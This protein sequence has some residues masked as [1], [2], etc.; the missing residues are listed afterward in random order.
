VAYITNSWSRVLEKL[1]VGHLVQEIPDLLWN[2]EVHY[3]GHRCP[4][5]DS[6]QSQI[7]PVYTLVHYFRSISILSS[8]LCLVLPNGPFLSGF[9]TKLWDKT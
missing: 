1:I 2:L 3:W 4:T 5:P 7:N 9:P 6:I 8:H